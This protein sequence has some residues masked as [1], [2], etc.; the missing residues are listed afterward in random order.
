MHDRIVPLPMVPTHREVILVSIEG[1][2]GLRRKLTTMG[3]REGKRFKVLHTHG[4]GPCI[5]LVDEMRLAL[6]HGMAHKMLVKQV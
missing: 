6:G 5:V 4:R 2:W 1:G 3:L